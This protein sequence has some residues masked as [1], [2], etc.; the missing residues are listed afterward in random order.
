LNSWSTQ[1]AAAAG[2][3]KHGETATIAMRQ[4]QPDTRMQGTFRDQS[5]RHIGAL[6]AAT[7]RVKATNLVR[8]YVL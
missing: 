7:I 5:L 4:T 8:P 1:R 6:P 3:A 2:S